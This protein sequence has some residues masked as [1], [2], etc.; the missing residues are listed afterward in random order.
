MYQRNEIP[1]PKSTSPKCVH[2]FTLVELLT[3]ITIIGILI[4]LLL[5]AVQSAREAARRMQ[6]SNNLKQIGLGC[7][8]HEAAQGFFPTG[9]WGYRWIG[10]AD[11]GAGRH[12]PGGWIYSILPYIEQEAVYMLPADG[13]PIHLTAKQMAGAAVLQ[14]TPIA[15]M[16]CPTRRQA[17]PYPYAL[18]AMFKPVNSD[19]P[20]PMVVALSDYA[21]NGGDGADGTGTTGSSPDVAALTAS[22]N[23]PL[24]TSPFDKSTGVIY[25]RSQ[26]QPAQI[27]DGS[28]NTYLVGERY[29][30]PDH[31]VDGKDPGDDATMYQG[32]GGD[33][34]RWTDS[35]KLPL[36]D[37]AGSMQTERFGSAHTDG[38]NMVFCDGSVHSIGYTIA[39]TAHAYL[40]N[41]KDGQTTDA[42][43]F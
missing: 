12:Q 31:Y 23:D 6:C 37:Q 8:Q 7:L 1:N 39:P 30:N 20:N 27:Y 29:L 28:S 13:D 26:I 11:R 19:D 15:L 21:G 36:Q 5:P 10:D 16:N 18:D 14:R 22:D 24:F 32:A 4:S 25:Y 42:S 34:M 9:G 17:V 38:F 3:V 35:T 43:K 33:V 40:G 2:G 41:R